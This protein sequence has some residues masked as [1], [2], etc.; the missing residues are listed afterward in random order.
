MLFSYET[1]P[2]LF[3]FNYIKEL[4]YKLWLSAFQDITFLNVFGEIKPSNC[5]RYAIC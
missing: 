4:V 3:T 1:Q 5:V 2:V